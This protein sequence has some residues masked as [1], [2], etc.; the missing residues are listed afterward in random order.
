MHGGSVKLFSL[1]DVAT[2]SGPNSKISSANTNQKSSVDEPDS[3]TMKHSTA[4]SPC[5]PSLH[6]QRDSST[7]LSQEDSVVLRTK[8]PKWPPVCDNYNLYLAML[9]DET[10]KIKSKFIT[11]FEDFRESFLSR[12]CETEFKKLVRASAIFPFK[13]ATMNE[14]K[15]NKDTEE[16]LQLIFDHQSYMNFNFFIK[17]IIG[18]T[19]SDQDK[20]NGQDYIEAFERY[21]KCR[22]HERGP[23]F[24]ANLD[25]HCNVLFV[26]DSNT[27][28]HEIG[29]I[30]DF[31]LF[32]SKL[33][34]MNSA[35][36]L[37][38]QVGIGSLVICLQIP[39]DDLHRLE[40]IPLFPRKLKAIKDKCVQSYKFEK[41]EVMLKHW[42]ML[43]DVILETPDSPVKESHLHEKQ[44]K[45]VTAKH[46]GKEFMALVYPDQFTEEST[47]D[48]GYIKYLEVLIRDHKEVPSIKGLYYPSTEEEGQKKYP[49]VIVEK[50]EPLKEVASSSNYYGES[51]V[52]QLSLLTSISSCMSRF[53]NLNQKVKVVMDHIFIHKNAAEM[54]AKLIPVYGQSFIG[55]QSSL[56][57]ETLSHDELL[58]MKEIILS[59]FS[60]GNIT[61]D[62]QLPEN[63]LL[64]NIFEQKW[65]SKDSRLRPA[66]YSVLTDELQH[67]LGK[68]TEI[69]KII[70][71]KISVDKLKV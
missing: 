3:S 30:S 69:Q 37:I 34:D 6:T 45:M 68:L 27:P 23:N 35:N 44:S 60:R 51:E 57:S 10:S 32:I 28:D 15:K 19:G 5:E 63:H 40:N 38:H 8:P 12:E 43:T 39:C 55:E 36:I 14:I 16:L 1:L 17:E 50:L 58:W 29:E 70:M 20:K 59:I 65:V 22:V 33:L 49:A 25:T 41:R 11:L 48:T 52:N 21:A 62:I 4:D 66:S 56:N 2:S 7:K 47:V 18:R 61:T 46:Q 13:K 67:L 54:E 42:R 53:E 71:N 9:R 26:I 64:K 24:S 31:Q